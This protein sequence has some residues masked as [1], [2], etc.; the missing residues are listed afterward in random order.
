MIETNGDNIIRTTTLKR[1]SSADI[2]ISEIITSLMYVI[3]AWSNLTTESSAKA[4][5][6]VIGLIVRVSVSL[7]TLNLLG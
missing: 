4:H 1:T 2:M 5:R 3:S 6:L 7:H